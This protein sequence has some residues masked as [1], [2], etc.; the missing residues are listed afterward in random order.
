MLSMEFNKP[1][2]LQSTEKQVIREIR[3]TVGE[4][5]TPESR[6]QFAPRWIFGKQIQTE[7]DNYYKEKAY[8]EVHI[9][10]LLRDEKFFSSNQLFHIKDDGEKG[11][12]KLN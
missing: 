3:Q 8:E 5:I 2:Q 11:K 1:H 6:L 4:K 9:K 12:M 7:K 10:S